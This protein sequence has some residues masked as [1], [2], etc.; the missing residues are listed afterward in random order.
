MADENANCATC[1]HLAVERNARGWPKRGAVGFCRLR[2]VSIENME[3]TWCVNHPQDNALGFQVAVGP[4]WVEEL[5]AVL[6][7]VP[8]EEDGAGKTCGFCGMATPGPGQI[9][10]RKQGQRKDFCSVDHYVAWAGER[11]PS[12][13]L[14]KDVNP[15]DVAELRRLHRGLCDAEA[16]IR[17][18]ESKPVGALEEVLKFTGRSLYRFLR[19]K[20]FLPGGKV[21][22]LWPALFRG[23]PPETREKPNPW[24]LEVQLS[25]RELLSEPPE[26]IPKEPSERAF[27]YAR[28][29]WARMVV[30]DLIDAREGPDAPTVVEKRFRGRHRPSWKKGETDLPA[31]ARRAFYVERNPDLDPELGE[32]F[33]AAQSAE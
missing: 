30:G 3:G 29:R 10:W 2:D 5:P 9:S 7:G 1:P 13:P 15:E 24:M 8:T 33:E 18:G 16:G 14:P 20:R 26:G 32:Y 23:G 22:H 12:I 25:L 17:D 4:H 27:E 21:D 6:G 28:V 31:N 19:A 11:D